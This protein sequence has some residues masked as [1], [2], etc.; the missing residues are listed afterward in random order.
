MKQFLNEY[1]ANITFMVIMNILFFLLPF[2]AILPHLI[3]PIFDLSLI[4]ILV[5]TGA[6]IISLIIFNTL[7]Y[8]LGE[9]W[10]IQKGD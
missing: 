7:G 9:L 5:H 6:M 4:Y 10:K 3:D 8:I 2:P 1:K